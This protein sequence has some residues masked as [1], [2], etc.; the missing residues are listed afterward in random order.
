M[1]KLLA[2]IFIIIIS[3]VIYFAQEER[4][5]NYY[6]EYTNKIGYK[7]LIIGSSSDVIDKYCQTFSGWNEILTHTCYNDPDWGYRFMTTNNDEIDFIW[8]VY[9]N[10]GDD[11]KNEDKFKYNSLTVIPIIN[12][13]ERRYGLDEEEFKTDQN[14]DKLSSW[15]FGNDSVIAELNESPYMNM[16][17]IMYQSK[18][19]TDF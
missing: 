9:I 1:R 5:K 2:A 8:M 11:A 19:S 10:G 17:S 3:V 13:L 6:Y 7:D 18:Y 15:S 12:Q 4:I 14:G 16:F